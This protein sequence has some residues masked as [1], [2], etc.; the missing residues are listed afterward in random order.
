MKRKVALY[1]HDILQNMQ[2]A[3]EFIQGLS[4]DQFA[5]DKKTFNAVV[6]AIEV[7]GEATKN[8]PASVRNKYTAVPWKEMAGMRDKVIHLYFGVD[9]EAV[10]LV[11]KERI[12]VIKPI[13][14]QVLRDLEEQ[15]K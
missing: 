15:E 5:K 6:R 2:D 11:A 13:I 14:E 3:E 9:R 10:W 1:V 4:Y 12:P 7:I 8:V